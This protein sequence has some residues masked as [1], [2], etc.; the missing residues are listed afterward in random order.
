MKKWRCTV[1]NYVHT[2]DTP[3]DKC[4]VCG[5]G[6]EKFV[7]IDEEAEAPVKKE[8][9]WRCT[10]C[11]Y[12][13]TGETPPD[14]CP[15]CGVG[16]DKF[17]LVEESPDDLPDEKREAIQQLLFNISYGL[18]VVSS[19]KEDKLNAMVSN[20]FIQVTN[21]PLKASVCLGKGTLTAEYVLKSGVFG[22]SIMGKENHDLVK[23]FGYQSGRD[24]DKFKD[25][26]YVTG[27]KTGCPGLLN[28]I[29]F[30]ECE[31][32]QTIDLGT[33]YMFIAKV[34]EGDAFTKDEPMTYAYYRATRY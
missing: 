6:P 2:G 5:V 24:V 22:V 28:S 27:E 26:S 31:V 17:V 33:H 23:H 11:N 3:P 18:Y 16:P 12:I 34:L 29:C 32:E 9:K 19:K 7:L 15:I 8:K 20:T 1:C 30:V 4:P 21:T 10:V 13:H 14:I 25:M